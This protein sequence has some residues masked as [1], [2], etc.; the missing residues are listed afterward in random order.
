[1][2]LPGLPL[3]LRK[4][5]TASSHE[6]A[7]RDKWTILSAISCI[8]FYEIHLPIGLES[9]ALTTE[10]SRGGQWGRC[11][12][13]YRVW[14]AAL[15][16]QGLWGSHEEVY[17]L[18]TGQGDVKQVREQCVDIGEEHW[19]NRVRLKLNYKRLFQSFFLF[20]FNIATQWF[21]VT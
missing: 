8:N 11:M 17:T 10:L 4:R 5:M 2:W 6:A 14:T 21:S 3:S 20:L 19:R 16:H 15:L 7:V 18:L 12:Y 13:V 1:M 9:G